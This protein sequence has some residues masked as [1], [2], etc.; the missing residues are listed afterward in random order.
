MNTQAQIGH[1]Q[2]PDPLDEALAPY[3]DFITEAEGWLDGQTVTTEDQ[4]K[5]VDAIAKQVKAAKKDLTNAQKSESAPLHDAWKAS[6]ARFKPTIDDL[7]RMAKGLAALVDGF[8]RKLAEEKRAKE[9]VAW[10]AAEKARKEA[11]AKAAAADTANIDQQREAEEARRAAQ[12]A[13]KAAQAARKDAASVKGLRT[14]TRY[15]ITDHKAA[16][17]DIAAN[18]RDAMTAFIEDYVRRN[19]KARAIKGVK[20]WQDRE[21]F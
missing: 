7:D 19:H 3:G 8:K 12:E 9:R 13:E 5:A 6:L 18:D 11:E 17:Y 20:V 10:E 1:N 16:L 21:A 2:A 4:M 14:V 15:E